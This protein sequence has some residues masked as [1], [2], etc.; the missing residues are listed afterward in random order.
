MFRLHFATTLREP[1]ERERTK[2]LRRE[3][4]YACPAESADWNY[5]AA[6]VRWRS[7][8]AAP[9]DLGLAW[10]RPRWREERR[11]DARTQER[12]IK[13]DRDVR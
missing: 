8:L 11:E 13:A 6:I 4:R 7:R 12:L 10:A 2:F 3:C 9:D 1:D 5:K